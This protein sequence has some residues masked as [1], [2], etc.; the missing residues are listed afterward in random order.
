MKSL[1]GK[2]WRENLKWSVL[3]MLVVGGL[4]FLTLRERPFT[5]ILEEHFL[6][7]LMAVGA[8]FGGAL[9]FLQVFLEAHGDKRSLLLHRP[10]SPSRIFAGKTIAGLALYLLALA[11]PFAG[12]VGWVATPGHIAAPFRWPMVLPGLADILTGAVYYFA[13]MLTAQREARWYG[14]RGLGLAVAV[15]CS[16]LVYILPEFRHA[17]AAILTLGVLL[18]VAAWG[19]FIA[20]GAYASQPRIAKAALV[21]T[22]LIALLVVGTVAQLIIGAWFDPNVRN[23]YEIDRNGQVLVVRSEGAEMSVTDLA[24]VEPQELRG[25]P[26]DFHLVREI[27]A[28]LAHLGTDLDVHWYRLYDRVFLPVPSHS[29][30]AERWYY[31]VDEARLVGFDKQSKQSI[32]SFGPDGFAPAGRES[33]EQFQGVLRYRHGYFMAALGSP[34]VLPFGE[35]VYAVDFTG[36]TVHPVFTPAQGETVLAAERKDDP[37]QKSPLTFV[38]T[39]TA[40]RAVDD[41][42]TPVFS[43]HPAYDLKDYRLQAARLDDAQR[44]F[45]WYTP[46]DRWE[47]EPVGA[48]QLTLLF[49]STY[50][51]QYL[52]TVWYQSERGPSYVVEYTAA[53]REIRCQ[54]LPPLP[55]VEPA[56]VQAAYGLLTPV[57]GVIFYRGASQYYLSPRGD[58]SAGLK[59]SFVA[60]FT[61][62]MLLSAVVCALTCSVLARRHAFSRARCVGWSV[63][64]L[65][66]GPSGLLLMLA[67]Q[68]WPARIACPGCRKPR[69]VTREVCEHCGAAHAAPALDGTE[70]FDAPVGT[71]CLAE[72]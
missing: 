6:G 25:Q 55:V 19:S 26:L 1:I 31:V 53:G 11:V 28:P 29:S 66:W 22:S 17:L 67:V 46:Y 2:E 7:V 16:L 61:A 49:L 38:L 18:A 70:V 4:L 20:G 12:A 3:A 42:G 60:A 63:C 36:R 58:W 35:G 56:P 72:S 68:E 51:F 71:P 33:G 14:S 13:G 52:P 50:A 5:S 59:G 45:V 24:R 40:V 54:T 41:A 57:A 27:E 15:L 34:D 32:G 37:K 9:G 65:L 8:L 69:I 64:G 43:T 23:Y 44:F 47:T 21:V 30:V 39:E 10:L 48:G 62:L